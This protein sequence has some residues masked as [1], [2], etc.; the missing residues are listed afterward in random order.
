MA[1]RIS[2][3]A[4]PTPMSTPY[5]GFFWEGAREG[6]LLIQRCADCATYQHPPGPMCPV[7]GGRMVTPVEVSGLGHIDAFTIIRRV[8]HPAFKSEVPYVVARILLDEQADLILVTNILDCEID[9]VE[10]GMRVKVVFKHE[11]DWTLPQFVPDAF[12]GAQS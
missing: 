8:F 10:T 4:R 12:E 5:N 1:D 11:G 2:I 7:C 3:V 6:R 9:S